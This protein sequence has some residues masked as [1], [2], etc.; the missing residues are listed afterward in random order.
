MKAQPL[1]KEL[2]FE[3]TAPSELMAFLIANMPNKSRMNIKTLLRDKQVYVDGKAISQYNHPLVPAQI[4]EIKTLKFRKESPIKG[5][6][7]VYE[8]PYLVVINKEAGML[9][10]ATEK[11]KEQTAYSLLNGHVKN[12]NPHGRI[13]VVHRL[14]R[15]T[16]GLMIYA[17]S[18]KIQAQLQ[19]AWQETKERVYLAITQGA[20]YPPSGTVESYLFESKAFIVYSSQNPSKGHKAITHYQTLKANQR[21]ALVQVTL[22]TGRKNQVR[23]HLQDLGHPVVGDAKYGATENPLKRLGL[24]AWKLAFKHPVTQEMMHFETSIPRKFAALF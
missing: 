2:F 8:D 1:R 16:S 22:A 13:F 3:V 24:H 11:E 9:S 15:D 5:L 20:I 14:D 17:K 7:I 23:V 12:A 18:E 21:Y 6:T 4:V 19:E 10:I